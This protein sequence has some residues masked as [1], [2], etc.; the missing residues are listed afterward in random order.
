VVEDAMT[1]VIQHKP[2]H[3]RFH[4]WGR[5]AAD[6]KIITIESESERQQDSSNTNKQDIQPSIQSTIESEFNN[7]KQLEP[8]VIV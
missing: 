8:D 5:P 4:G 3:S 6:R 7:N 2:S 1:F